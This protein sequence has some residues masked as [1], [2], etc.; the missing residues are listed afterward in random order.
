MV[1]NLQEKEIDNS[2]RQES[3]KT[4]EIKEKIAARFAPVLWSKEVDETK[5]TRKPKSGKWI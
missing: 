4:Q 3:F 2:L 1:E 5:N